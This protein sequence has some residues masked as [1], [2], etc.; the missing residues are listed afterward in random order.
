MYTL[1]YFDKPLDTLRK[2]RFFVIRLLRANDEKV[3]LRD[4]YPGRRSQTHF[5]PGYHISPFQGWGKI[6]A[7]ILVMCD[8]GFSV[9]SGFTRSG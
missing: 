5:A 8:H 6:E 1:I 9:A 4:L 3:G 2:F 7:E